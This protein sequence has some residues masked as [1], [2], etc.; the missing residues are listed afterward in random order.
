MPAL[1][2]LI[3]PHKHAHW[4][5][6][7]PTALS[8]GR[9]KYSSPF[10]LDCVPRKV[11]QSNSTSRPSAAKKSSCMATKSLSPMPLGAILTRVTSAMAYPPHLVW[12]RLVSPHVNAVLSHVPPRHHAASAIGLPTRMKTAHSAHF[13]MGRSEP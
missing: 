13:P 2:L 4:I 7:S 3:V 11:F 10:Q 5:T 8:C 12:P 1:A 9:W 6:C